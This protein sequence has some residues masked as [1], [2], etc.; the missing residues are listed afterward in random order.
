MMEAKRVTMADIAKE[1]GVSKAS[2]SFAF[3][4]PGKIKKE[5]YLRIMDVAKKLDY[6]PDPM[7]KRLS[8]GKNYTIGFLLPQ[9]I[10]ISLNN[11][12]TI[13]VLKG[14]GESCERNGYS[15]NLIPPLHSS[16]A[17]AVKFA[18]VDGLITMGISIDKKIKDALRSRKIPVVCI[19]GSKKDG[20][21]SVN[22]DD[23]R[24]AYE[25]ISYALRRG[26]RDFALIALGRDEY[27]KD[28]AD[29]DSTSNR[30]LKGYEKAL[31]EYG[32]SIS[33][34]ILLTREPTVEDGKR[35]LDDIISAGRNVT[36]IISMADAVCYGIMKRAKE[37]GI[38]IPGKLSIIGFDGLDNIFSDIPLTT[39][40][41]AAA[42]KGSKAADILFSLINGEEDKSGVFFVDYRLIEGE[43]VK[44][45]YRI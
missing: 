14:I 40:K 22:I 6:I 35:A 12:Y 37:L 23:E 19:D 11:P 34:A 13:E 15:M 31:K 39:M 30:R 44:D 45:G 42:E 18:A 5:T 27:V 7:A 2:V 43:S 38:D 20:L 36:C 26:H 10:D 28:K 8:E 4:N 32:L 33:D 41:Q 25:Q 16:I 9:H 24:A 1:C 29:K 21:C 3:N 17:E